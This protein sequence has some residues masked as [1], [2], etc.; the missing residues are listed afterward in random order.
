MDPGGIPPVIHVGQYDDDY[1]LVFNPFSA[2]GVFSIES[3]STAEIRGTKLDGNGYSAD[4][5][6]EDGLITVAG[7]KQ[8]TAIAGMNVFEIVIKS[9]DKVLSSTNFCLAVEH[10]AM[11]AETVVSESV[12][13]E[14]GESVNAWLDE[15]GAGAGLTDGIKT[16]MLQIAQKVVYID[17]HGQDYYDDLYEALY[18]PVNLLSIAAVY[19]QSGTVYDTDSLDVL[20]DDLVVTA[21]YDD[22]TSEV[23]T[24]Y[25]LSG[26]LIEGTSTITVSYGGKTD[27]FTVTVSSSTVYLYNWDFTQSLTDSVQGITAT[28]GGN[29]TQDSTGLHITAANGY[30]DLGKILAENQAYE[31]DIAS[32]DTSAWTSGHGRLFIWYKSNGS[33]FIYRSDGYWTI[34]N[35]TWSSPATQIAD[36]SYFANST[37]KIVVGS[38]SSRPITIYKDGVE[39]LAFTVSNQNPVSSENVACLGGGGS[40]AAFSMTITGLRVYSTEV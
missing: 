30:V 32:M 21:Y 7:D 11:D 37:L 13:K 35:G 4:A 19:T 29:A 22:S 6:I 23:V 10:A 8:M 28:L 39:V 15:H 2:A 1:T 24:T 16:A 20:K 38:G 34:Y 40:N 17:E 5:E 25:T 36:K 33:G 26:T 31:I 3:G 18:P 14:I 27:T 12:I 9:G